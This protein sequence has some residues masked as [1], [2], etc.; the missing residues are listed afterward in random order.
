MDE[1]TPSF[2]TICETIKNTELKSG[3]DD[4]KQMR[5]AFKDCVEK[6]HNRGSKSTKG[7]KSELKVPEVAAMHAS[8]SISFDVFLWMESMREILDRIPTLSTSFCD[9]K[10]DLLGIA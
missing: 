2:K 9:A 6:Y 1:K 8:E 4:V 5:D 10:Q 3:P 7:E